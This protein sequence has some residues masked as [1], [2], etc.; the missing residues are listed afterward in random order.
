MHSIQPRIPHPIV[1]YSLPL[2]LAAAA[3]A[4]QVGGDPL[5]LALRFERGAVAGGE[6][7]R[8]LSGHLVHLGWSHLWLNI[9]GL[10]L[11]WALVGPLLSI[12]QWWI[13]ALVCAFGTGL[14][15]V[16][17]V[18]ELEWYVGL[19]GVLHGLLAAGTVAGIAAGQRDM[20]LLL[21]ALAAK[22]GW[23]QWRGPLPGSVEAVGGP[24]VVDAHLYGAIAG[25]GMALAVLVWRWMVRGHSSRR[26]RPDSK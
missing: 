14:G 1:R 10:T 26:A 22:L 21:L 24:V 7:W 16:L 11:I 4:F 23:E 18:P 5:I 8:L 20:G 6:W 17:G 9:A 3:L 25:V 12:R 19:S 2:A 15:L 13:T